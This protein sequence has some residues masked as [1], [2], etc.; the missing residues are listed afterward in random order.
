MADDE[1]VEGE[2]AEEKPGNAEGDLKL[3]GE[4]FTDS[5]A[6]DD[7]FDK[8]RA[9]HTIRTLR[10]AEKQGKQ[11]AKERDALAARLKEIEDAEK[12]DLERAQA[13]VA[14]LEAKETGWETE[15]RDTML[16][17]AAHALKDE[18]GVADVDL[19][20]AALDRSAIEYTDAG[21]PSNLKEQLEQL[22][23]RK[24]ILKAQQGNGGGAPNLNGGSGATGGPAPALTAEELAEAKRHGMA[25]ERYALAK[26][27]GGNIQ[28][29]L[30]QR[31]AA[32][33]S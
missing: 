21:E 7:D 11:A 30:A 5:G 23:E 10:E 14:E 19:A 20:L 16:R 12:T 33:A 9:L 6:A 32:A 18:L 28:E 8:E 24:P 3:T 31:K 29:Y 25:P 4:K 1:T 26:Q 27:A 15:R 17:L 22:L 13:R 2:G